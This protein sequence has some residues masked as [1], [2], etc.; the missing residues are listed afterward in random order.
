MVINASRVK[1]YLAM[2]G[3]ATRT[4]QWNPHGHHGTLIATLPEYLQM[5]PWLVAEAIL[6]RPGLTLII[7]WLEMPHSSGS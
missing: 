3:G 4:I 6:F 5:T 2:D 7:R 1:R